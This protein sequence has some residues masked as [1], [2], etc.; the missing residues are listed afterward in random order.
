MM[1]C[2]DVNTSRYDKTEEILE[3]R[4]KWLDLAG[5]YLELSKDSENGAEFTQG[6]SVQLCGIPYLI[7]HITMLY[8]ISIY[9]HCIKKNNCGN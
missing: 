2:N 9:R 4:Q 1:I 6:L 3:L 5:L 7:K 8:Y